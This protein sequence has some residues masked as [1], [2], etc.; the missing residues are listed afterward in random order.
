MKPNSVPLLVL[1]ISKYE[2][3]GAFAADPEINMM[4]CFTEIM[5]QCEFV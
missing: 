3:Q 2:Y 1:T 4:A 5:M